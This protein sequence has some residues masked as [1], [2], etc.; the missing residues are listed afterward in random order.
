MFVVT[1]NE[2]GYATPQIICDRCGKP[3]EKHGN[4]SW[5]PKAGVNEII[6]L[7]VQCTDHDDVSAPLAGLGRTLYDIV[8]N[9]KIDWDNAKAISDYFAD[10]RL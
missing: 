7:H 1:V 2:S 6:T 9:A 4:I 3:I 8:H 10:T 5:Q